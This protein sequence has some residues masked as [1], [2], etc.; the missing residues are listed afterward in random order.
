MGL[1][2]PVSVGITV[3]AGNSSRGDLLFGGVPLRYGGAGGHTVAKLTSE[4]LDREV[5][6]RTVPSEFLKTVRAHP[7]RTALR[8]RKPEGS[9]G[10]WTFREYAERTARVAAALRRRGVV[11]GDRIVLMTRNRPEFHAVDMAATFVGATPISIYNSSSPEQI[12]YLV[13]HCGARLGVVED[14]RFLAQFQAVR[15]RLPRLEQLGVLDGGDGAERACDFTWSSLQDEAPDDLAELSSIARPEDL[16]TVIYTSGTTG[17]PKGVMITHANVAW[18]VESLKRTIDFP[19]YVGKK[20]ISYLPMAHIAERMTS[21]YQQAF[22]AYEVTTCPDPAKIAEY[23][24]LVRPNFMFGVP[25]VWEKVYAGVHAALA[26]DPEKQRKFSEAVEAARPIAHA[27]AWGEATAD[28]R[29]TWEFLDAVAFSTVRQLVGL[30]QLELAITGAAPIPAEMLEW[31]RAIGIPLAEIYGMSESSGPMTFSAWKV[32]PGTVGRAIVGCDVRLAADGEVVCRGGNVFKG[33]LDDPVKTAEALDADGW[34]HSG[35][36]GEVDAD[37]YFRIVDRKK[38]L[39]ITAGGKNISPANL[40]ASLKMIPLVGQ[41][42]AIGDRRPFVSALLVLDPDAAR[43]F[44]AREGIEFRSLAELAE[45]PR[46]Q[47]VVQ[48]GLEKAMTSF[49]NAERVKKV[50]LLGEE[51][52]PD[53]QC[54]T[55]TSKLKRRGIVEKYAREIEALYA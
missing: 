18:T 27:L 41:A 50:K 14:G 26:A 34:L 51:W 53:S 35:D 39:I 48:E 37:G 10:E 8:W 5:A 2:H 15:D 19:E 28:Q 11:R 42:C 6:G 21:H 4:D 13:D 46:V 33:Y 24:R 45:H 23:A 38:E 17:P 40:E 49:N 12:S 32:K 16:A 47:A 1:G 54:L 52:L 55:P 25:R 22:L 43:S 31:F 3:E 9:L 7:D 20:L 29:K 36:I 30:D 44:A